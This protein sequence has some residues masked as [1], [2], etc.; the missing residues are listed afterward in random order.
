MTAAPVLRVT[1]LA[2]HFATANGIVRAVD[3]VSLEVGAGEILGLVGESGSGKTMVGLSILGLVDPPGRIVGGRVEL[4]GRNLLDCRE[5]E[6]RKLRGDRISMVFQDPQTTLSPTLRIGRQ[7]MNVLH[8]HRRLAAAEARVACRDALARLG[9]PSPEERL[10]AFP[11]QLSGGM[12]QR[13]CIAMAM[14]NKPALIVADEPTTALDVTTQAQILEEVR[15]LAADSGT[16][17]IWVTHDLAVVSGLADRIAVM[18]AGQIVEEGPA[19]R[20]TMAAAHPYTRGLLNYVPSNNRSA[21]RLPQIPG[22]AP[23]PG[24]VSE[25]CKFRPRCSRATDRCVAAPALVPLAG[26]QGARCFHPFAAG[27]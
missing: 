14:L 4:A 25:G 18:Y 17:F 1:D 27:S 24:S 23:R 19:E 16:S 5:P 7:M 8:A 6:L 9:I 2:T 21:A 10:D 20:V 15:T 3:G 12:R 26:T 11:H 13:V 22:A